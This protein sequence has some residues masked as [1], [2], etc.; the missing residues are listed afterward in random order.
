[1]TRFQRELDEGA[2]EQL[3]SAYAG[4]AAAVARQI[5]KYRGQ[6]EDAVQEAFMRVIRRRDQYIPSHAFSTWFYTI[7][8]HVCI[9]MRRKTERDQHLVEQLRQQQGGVSSSQTLSEH[10]SLLH[11]LPG[12]EKSVLELRVVHG[13]SFKQIADALNISEEA[14]KKRAQRGL[15]RLRERLGADAQQQR[16][17]V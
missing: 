9:D 1:M 6:A 11:G 5:L 12:R 15:R 4:P 16:Q 3:V 7:L 13:L 2:F 8:R 10:G 14:A 17:A